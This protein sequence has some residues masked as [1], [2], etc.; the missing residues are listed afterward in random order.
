MFF[1]GQQVG[2]AVTQLSRAGGL[3]FKSQNGQIQRWSPRGRPCFEDT[4]SIAWFW[5][6][7][8]SLQVFEKVLS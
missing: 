3:R 4:F 7:P 1:S 5:L 6:L 2:Q 8:R